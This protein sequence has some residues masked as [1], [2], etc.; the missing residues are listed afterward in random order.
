MRLDE[1]VILG[2]DIGIASIGWALLRD[3]PATGEQRLL[4]RQ[5]ADGEVRYALGSR[6]FSAPEDAKT[7]ELLNVKRRSARQQRRVIR[8]RAQRMRQVRRLLAQHGMERALDARAF[9]LPRGKGTQLDPWSLRREGLG[10]LLSPD[11]LACVLLHMARHR[12]FLSNSKRDAA[13]REETGKM[14]QG[15][16]RIRSEVQEALTTAGAFMA[17]QPRKRN[18]RDHAGNAVYDRTLPRQLLREETDRLCERQQALGSAVFSAE[19]RDAYKQIAFDQRPL[20]SVAG[21]VGRCVF[22]ENERRAPA[23]APTA[24]RFR[25][26][27]RLT[28]LRLKNAAG[29]SRSLRAE[30]MRRVLA[31]QGRQPQAS[32]TYK[33]LRK[34][35]R[36]P[37]GT[38]FENLGR[39]GRERDG[40]DPE[41]ADIVRRS[42]AALAGSAVFLKC[43]GKAPLRASMSCACPQRWTRR[44]PAAWT[45]WPASS[46]KMTTW[47]SSGRSWS[48]CRCK[49]R[50]A[51]ACGRRWTREP[52]PFSGEPCA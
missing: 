39:A 50:S 10:R 6:V 5:G 20:A 27:Q 7:L 2:L 29:E 19:L 46:R 11:E 34:L 48:A 52:L 49:A 15:V 42:G 18:R 4:S 8:R 13:D 24:E 1:N 25:L 51:R 47:P 3:D 43:L 17:A 32:V 38:V 21:M 26:A 16:S 45:I 30:E 37:D 23:F 36:L 31:V 33:T 9:H 35:L 28:V 41:A 12:G 14:L 22:L 44:S 40:K